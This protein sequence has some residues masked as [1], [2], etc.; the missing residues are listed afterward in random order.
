MNKIAIHADIKEG[1]LRKKISSSELRTLR[2]FVFLTSYEP[3]DIK[4]N[5]FH[6][7]APL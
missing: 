4:Q 1:P 2:F 5:N 3:S 7:I 6:H